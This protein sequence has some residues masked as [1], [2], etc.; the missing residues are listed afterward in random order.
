LSIYIVALR[1]RLLLNK[2]DKLKT[3]LILFSAFHLCPSAGNLLGSRPTNWKRRDLAYM[4]RSLRVSQLL[5]D[6]KLYA[7]QEGAFRWTNAF[8]NVNSPANFSDTPAARKG[9]KVAEAWRE[10]APY[11][12][13]HGRFSQV[14]NI[15][16]NVPMHFFSSRDIL[17]CLFLLS[18]FEHRS[19]DVLLPHHIVYTFLV[20]LCCS[21]YLGPI[22][23]EDDYL[24]A[25]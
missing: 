15:K 20:L 13:E 1:W 22:R 8:F 17:L 3:R 9:A 21:I 6:Q 18:F 12:G 5:G 25:R 7:L 16:K 11:P 23:D 19:K 10:T 4:H 2:S 14:R 24:A